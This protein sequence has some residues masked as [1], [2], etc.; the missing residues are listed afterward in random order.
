MKVL[1]TIMCGLVVLFAGGCVLLLIGSSGMSGTLFGGSF[2]VLPAGLAVLNALAI[3]ALWGKFTS[4]SGTLLALAI[5]D[6]I[7]VAMLVV[8]LIGLV[9]SDMEAAMFLAI[10]ALPLAVKGVLTFYCWRKL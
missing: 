1:L 9:A 4:M 6:G 10:P 2:V 8:P 5:I 3:G 7:A